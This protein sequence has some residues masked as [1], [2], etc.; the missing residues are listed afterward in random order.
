MAWTATTLKVRYVELAPLADAIVDAALAEAVAECDARVFDESYDH[1]V[2]L[3]AAHK[4]AM[5]PGGQTA[6]QEGADKARTVYLE[7]WERL[8][9]AR[10]G[11]FWVTGVSL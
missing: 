3:L 9:R 10:A 6:R 4:L 2:G 11:G 8:A 1:A 7:E 5:G